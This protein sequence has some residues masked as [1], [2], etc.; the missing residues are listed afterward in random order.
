MNN[1]FNSLG[2]GVGGSLIPFV[3]IAQ[4]VFGDV[5]ENLGAFG[6]LVDLAIPIMFTLVIL[7]FFWNV[8]WYVKDPDGEEKAARKTRILWGLL[9]LFVIASIWGIV[10]IIQNALGV[11]DDT[12]AP[13]ITTIIPDRR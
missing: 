8:F 6:D 7:F 1:I 3:V 11:D 9:G 5:E 2:L 10:S 13:N 12:I 4:D